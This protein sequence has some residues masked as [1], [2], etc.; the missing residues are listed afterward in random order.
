MTRFRRVFEFSRRAAT[1]PVSVAALVVA[2]TLA[3]FA[4]GA[5]ND[6]VVE[7]PD[8]SRHVAPLLRTYCVGC[9][10]AA[11]REG[12]LVLESYAEMLKGGENGAVL[13]AGH[14]D[15]SR[16]VRVL[17]GE[18]KPSMPPEDNE[19]PTDE[20]IAALRSWID[21]G[22][23]GPDGGEPDPT[24]LITPRVEPTAAVREPVTAV[25]ISPKGDVAAL[26]RYGEVEIVSLADQNTLHTLTGHRGS[27]NALSFSDDG[28]RLVAAG[29][30]AGLFG[31]A[32][33]WNVADGQLIGVFQ[34]HRDSLFAA[35]ISPD[36]TLL[37]TGGYDQR[38]MLWDIA[39]GKSLA[40]LEGHNGA[41][42]ELSFHPGGK[43]LASA[44]GDRTVK[45]WSVPGGE[46]LDTFG[47]P[48]HELYALAF[49]PDGERLAA[50][51]VDN[52]IRVWRISS[53]G[54]EGTNPLLYSRFAHDAPILRLAWSRDGRTLVSAGEDQLIKV[55][56]ALAM[57]LRGTLVEQPDWVSGLAVSPDGGLV[58]AGRLDGTHASYAV[59]PA[60]DEADIRSRRL[61]EVPPAVD[62]GPQP[63]TAELAR[64][65]EI[66]PNDEPAQATPLG[67]PGVATGVIDVGKSESANDFDL[68]AIEAKAGDQWI[69]EVNAARSGSPLDS[70]VEVLAA[71]GQPIERLLLRA[72]RDSEIEFRPT[73]SGA[74]GFRLKNW[75]EIELRQ[76]IYASGEVIKH[77]RQRRGPDADND[78][79]P[80][81]GSR[82]AYFDTTSRAHPL[83]QLCYVVEPFAVGTELPDN[84]LPVF[85]L[86]FENDDESERK[87]GSDSRLTFVA[88]E[89]GTYLVR[90][91]DVRG[92]AGSDY[93]YELIVRRPQPDFKVSVDGANPTIA[94]ESGK[95][96]T[97]KV[98]RV[99]NFNG[100]V[101]VEIEGLP[102]GFAVTT[103]IVI[104]EGHYEAKGVIDALP[105]AVAP[106]DENA[107]TTKLTASAEVAGKTVTHDAGT[108]GTIKL[109]ERPKLVVHLELLESAAVGATEPDAPADK[110]ESADEGG[111]DGEKP[112]A[113]VPPEIVIQP[114]SSVACRLRV[115][116]N[117]F[118][119]RINFEIENLPHGIIVDDIGLSGV[120]IPEGQTER[121]IYLSAEKW[122]SATSR[123]FHAVAKA[124]GDQAS[125]PM[126]LHVRRADGL[127]T[128]DD[129]E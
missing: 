75:E 40:T 15:L 7:V 105:G 56:N 68:F 119:D 106:T 69:V 41:V 103:P 83:G 35:R 125:L 45:L 4:R 67:I 14:G 90:V 88:P 57:T 19:R 107:A 87:L 5:Q 74:R 12:G 50:A 30:E 81:Q 94:A 59:P 8:Y 104:E 66:E 44:S 86:Y 93:R 25:A 2:L 115:E 97:V 91:S 53:T 101:R 46:R 20:E 18:A 76:Y 89:D 111:V 39:S 22:A 112:A 129:R 54:Q 27:V 23:K 3:G 117:G 92:F 99:D 43:M 64:T 51:G 36:G 71:D 24:I 102:P 58:L 118:D 110:K 10:N 108:L 126:L 109:A 122:V 95:S 52:R 80:D 123:L 63:P 38:V 32:R 113:P 85:P 127:A 124:E 70:K 48:L 128:A 72:V 16:I 78:F 31:E 17:T 13:T 6:G 26:A 77:Y 42:F 84:G 21:A 116:R 100:P 49:S 60:G 37:A 55:W 120:L 34:G 79:Y 96:F 28:S 82:R 114:G 47:Q 9:H 33:L 65:A 62:Y 98:E 121:V 73:T 29:G 11:D 1:F 61:G